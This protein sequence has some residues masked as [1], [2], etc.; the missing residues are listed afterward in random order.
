MK[1][2][3]RE[4]IYTSRDNLK[5]INSFHLEN[6][7]IRTVL[8]SVAILIYLIFL[9]FHAAF[10]KNEYSRRDN[11]FSSCQKIPGPLESEIFDSR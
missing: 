9:T 4:F 8:V 3:H 1:K 6:A 11:F 2:L 5:K 10:L 7:K